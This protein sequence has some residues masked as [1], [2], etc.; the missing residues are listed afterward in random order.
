MLPKYSLLAPVVNIENLDEEIQESDLNGQIKRTSFAQAVYLKFKIDVDQFPKSLNYSLDSCLGIKQDDL[1]LCIGRDSNLTLT[2][3]N[4][5][6]NT[7]L[8]TYPIY[9]PGIYAYI[10]NPQPNVQEKF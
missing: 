7:T 6:T 9:Q 8:I 1:W 3:Y 5:V 10:I 2:S 4:N